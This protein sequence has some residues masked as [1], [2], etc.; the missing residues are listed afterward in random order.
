MRGK[1]GGGDDDPNDGNGE[2]GDEFK[3]HEQIPHPY[4][5]L[6]WYAIHQRHQ[7]QSGQSNPFIDPTAG[8]F[9][10]CANGSPDNIFTKNNGND[11]L[12]AWLQHKHSAPS[13]QESRKFPEYFW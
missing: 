7:R 13:E 9:R 8:I 11:R 5:K 3:E 1:T 6:G 12:W 10:V 4:R 2:Q